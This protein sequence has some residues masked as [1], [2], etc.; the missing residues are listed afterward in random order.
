MFLARR[1]CPTNYLLAFFA[2]IVSVN[3]YT[4]CLDP[5]TGQQ[6]WYNEFHDNTTRKR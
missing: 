6:R 1:H 4:Y 5:L 3:G 2:G